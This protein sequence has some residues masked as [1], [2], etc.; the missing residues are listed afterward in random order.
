MAVWATQPAGY[1]VDTTP[2]PPWPQGNP[3]AAFDVLVRFLCGASICSTVP[4]T[5]QH[6][7]AHHHPRGC[8]P[9]PVQGGTACG[10]QSV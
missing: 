10:H 1:T 8:V 5:V 7:T 3:T 4:K 6:P 2:G 9:R